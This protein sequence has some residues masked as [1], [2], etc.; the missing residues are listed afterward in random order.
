MPAGPSYWPGQ[1]S[2]QDRRKARRNIVLEDVGITA[3][4]LDRYYT[5]VARMAPI[6]ED[7]DTE[8]S[9]DETISQWIQD[10]FEDGTPLHMVGDALSGLHHFEPFT[11]KRLHKSWRLYS[12]WRRFEVPCRAPPLTQELVLAMA[13]WLISVDELTMS[14]L[15]LLGFHCL[16]RTGE[17]LQ[18]RPCDFILDN[19]KGL[20]SLPS[21]KSGV[22]NNSKE[23]VSIHD[24][25]T[26][27]TVRAMLQLKS[28]WGMTKVPCWDRSGISFRNLF[29]DSLAKLE[30]TALGFRP[31]SLRRGGATYEMQV[32]GLM[33]RTLMRGRWR[34]SNI[35]RI[36]ISDGLSMLPSLAMTMRS[37]HLVA[38]F[39]S[40]FINE[41]QAFT[42][43]ERGNKRHKGTSHA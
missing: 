22:R 43:G 10:E 21:S 14:A 3:A 24:T 37:K 28:Q 32:H 27:E 9:L 30:I 31:Y 41:H 36:Y 34:S 26:L 4:T 19:T 7:V 16:L 35:A 20:V 23:S 40:I 33:E 12:I 13:G 42:G 38:K 29:R 6:L 1:A 18:I 25:C 39:S 15:V 5:A 11:R 17:L 8:A 2:R